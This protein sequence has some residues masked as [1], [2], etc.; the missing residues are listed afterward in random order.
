M[1][2]EDARDIFTGI[3]KLRVTDKIYRKRE[4]KEKQIEK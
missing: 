1:M 3:L 4:S 2:A